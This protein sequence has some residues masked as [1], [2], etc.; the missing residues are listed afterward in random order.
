MEL[1]CIGGVHGD[2]N[3]PTP[4]LCLLLKMILIQP[5]DDIIEEFIKNEAFRYVRALGALYLRL[6]RSDLDCYKHLEPLFKDMQELRHL[7]PGSSSFKILHMDEFIFLLLRSA[8]VC[9]V[10]LLRLQKRTIFE[11]NNELEPK[12]FCDNP[13]ED[14]LVN[15]DSDDDDLAEYYMSNLEEFHN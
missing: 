11:Q 15:G 14:F 10:A 8:G 9:D 4:F 13:L 6:T 5:A 1:N 3:E 2:S 12:D 7:N